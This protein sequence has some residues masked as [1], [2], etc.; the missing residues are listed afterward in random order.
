DLADLRGALQR[1]EPVAEHPDHVQAGA[2][3][4]RLAGGAAAERLRAPARTGADARRLNRSTRGGDRVATTE[5]HPALA[6]MLAGLANGE[7]VDL[8]VTL[9]EHLPAAWPAHMPFQRKV[10]SWFETRHGAPQDTQG[11]RGPYHTGWVTLDEHCGTHVDA[12]SHFI[13]PPDSGLPNASPLGLISGADLDLRDLVGPAADIDVT[14]MF[15]QA[16][17]GESPLVGPE[18]IEAW[19]AEHG[20]L[21]PGDVVLFATGWDRHYRP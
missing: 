12:P 9:A 4:H 5:E 2:P 10:Y 18:R 13:P 3:G 21:Q 8:T 6:A 1:A 17:P 15:E 20:R 14:D 7:I 19:E 11:W 16:G